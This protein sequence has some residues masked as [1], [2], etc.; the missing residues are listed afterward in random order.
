MTY[1]SHYIVT[2]DR[3]GKSFIDGLIK[4]IKDTYE[5][6]ERMPT[7]YSTMGD[8]GLNRINKIIESGLIR[9]E[10]VVLLIDGHKN[11][12]LISRLSEVLKNHP[13]RD[14]VK[15]LVFDSEIEDWILK[16]E[17]QNVNKAR[18]SSAAI[19]EYKKYDLPDYASKINLKILE[20]R[21]T[22]FKEFLKILD[23]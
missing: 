11:R 15:L 1:A 8:G 17:K 3:Y 23:P 5:Y 7:I 14:K 9:H 22:T 20:K 2:T 13:K 12:A 16:S 4:K 21:D 18:K 19:K 6:P 10:V